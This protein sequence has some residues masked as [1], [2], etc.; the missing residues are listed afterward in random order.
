MA[1]HVESFPLQRLFC[2]AVYS[3]LKQCRRPPTMHGRGVVVADL[4]VATN[5]LVA[6]VEEE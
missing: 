3:A 6:G 1:A 2:P 5:L 4:P